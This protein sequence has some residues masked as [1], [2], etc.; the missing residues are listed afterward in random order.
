[1]QIVD[2]LTLNAV[3]ESR[4]FCSIEWI[5]VAKNNA[6][7]C[8]L[9]RIKFP[10]VIS[11]FE[12]R[13]WANKIGYENVVLVATRKLPEPYQSYYLSTALHGNLILETLSIYRESS[14]ILRQLKSELLFQNLRRICHVCSVLLV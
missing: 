6:F 5:S 9:T 7:S 1:M 8:D 14:V 3:P 11:T 10:V 2:V 4:Q 12:T 13:V